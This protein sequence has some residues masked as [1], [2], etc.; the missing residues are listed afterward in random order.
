[1]KR[2]SFCITCKNRFH[3]ISQTLPLNLADNKDHR[4]MIEFVV[5]DFSSRDGLQDWIFSNFREPLDEGYLRYIF[6]DEMKT[7]HASIAK[8]TAHYHA[9]GE[10]LMNLDGDN[11]TG[12]NGGMYIYDQFLKYGDKLLFHQHNGIRGG[13]T[14]GRIGMHRRF[15]HEIGGYDESFEPMGNQDV[16]L[17]RRLREFGLTYKCFPGGD[18]P[19][20]LTNSKTESI[21]FCRPGLTWEQMERK[22]ARISRLNIYTGNLIANGGVFGYRKNILTYRNGR[23]VNADEVER[24]VSLNVES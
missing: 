14:C 15:F 21:Q 3:Q 24:H 11:F 10:Y 23:M 4:D 13:G 17:I 16:D 9:S 6:T 7:W 8:N 19:K 20:A 22:N 1:M 18:F 5:V 2:I 12:S